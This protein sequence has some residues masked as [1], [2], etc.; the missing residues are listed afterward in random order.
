VTKFKSID[1]GDLIV[2]ERR[3]WRV[4]DCHYGALGHEDMISIKCLDKKPGSAEG[5]V[6]DM[7]VP[8]DLIPHKSIYRAVDHDLWEAGPPIARNTSPVALAS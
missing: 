3:I 2:M 1:V 4:T 8:L 7:L 5:D 6:K